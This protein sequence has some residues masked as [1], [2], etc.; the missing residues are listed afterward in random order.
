MIH[1]Y[2]ITYVSLLKIVLYAICMLKTGQH[3]AQ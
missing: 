2:K 1:Y 3:K